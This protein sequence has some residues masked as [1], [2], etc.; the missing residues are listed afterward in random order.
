MMFEYYK[1]IFEYKK[2]IFNYLEGYLLSRQNIYKNINNINI[3]K[4]RTLRNNCWKRIFEYRERIKI[5][6]EDV[7]IK[8][9]R[10]KILKDNLLIWEA[11]RGCLTILR[12]FFSII[13]GCFS[14]KRGY[15][16][17]IRCFNIAGGYF[18][19]WFKVRKFFVH[20]KGMFR[21]KKGVQYLV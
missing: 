10:L 3:Y 9:K 13:R 18:N 6:E 12:E 15:F 1:T 16:N 21:Y 4:K 14:K 2:K 11:L 20:Y 7:W 19:D 17:G 5:I 8:R